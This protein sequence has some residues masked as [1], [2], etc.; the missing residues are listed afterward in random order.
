MELN[1]N[2]RITSWDDR[3]NASW[4]LKAGYDEEDITEE[5]KTIFKKCYSYLFANYVNHMTPE[6]E[7]PWHS[8]WLHKIDV[9]LEFL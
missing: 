8:H 6:E 3:D 9:Y 5:M 7:Q 4:L 2:T 1:L